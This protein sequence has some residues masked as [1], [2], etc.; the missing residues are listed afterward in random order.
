MIDEHKFGMNYISD[1]LDVGFSYYEEAYAATDIKNCFAAVAGALKHLTP[2]A[3]PV[4]CRPKVACCLGDLHYFYYQKIRSASVF[5]LVMHHVSVAH[6]YAGAEKFYQ[7]AAAM[8]DYEGDKI[9]AFAKNQLAMFYEKSDYGNL[10]L[11]KFEALRL[12]SLAVDENLM[13]DDENRA[14][15]YWKRGNR[16]VAVDTAYEWSFYKKDN[17]S[18]GEI[19]SDTVAREHPSFLRWPNLKDAFHL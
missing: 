12:R 15:I 3:S 16:E 18:L 8:P 2:L 1:N 10:D 13:M 5:D 9:P 17:Q 11:N 14:I 7:V 6:Y 19:N 4:W